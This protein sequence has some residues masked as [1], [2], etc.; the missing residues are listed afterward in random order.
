MKSRLFAIVCCAVLSLFLGY[1]H[2]G[3]DESMRLIVFLV[4]LFAM[5]IHLCLILK[6]KSHIIRRALL[7]VVWVFSYY[8]VYLNF[9]ALGWIYF[10]RENGLY[11]DFWSAYMWGVNGGC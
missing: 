6:S 10:L 7:S 2:C 5:L 1:Y 8:L 9:G 11:V 3:A 4:L